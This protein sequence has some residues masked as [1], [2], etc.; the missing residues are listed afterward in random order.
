MDWPDFRTWALDQRIW[1]LSAADNL[2]QAQALIDDGDDLRIGEAKHILEKLFERNPNFDPAYIEV[3]RIA[4]KADWGPEGLHQVEDLLATALQIRPGN[5]DAKI[6]LAY[7]YAHQ[8]RFAKAEALSKA[9]AA[10]GTSNLW[11]WSN[12]GEMLEMEHRPDQA[13]AKYRRAI[14][15][16]VTRDRNDRARNFAYE[17]LLGIL[18]AREDFDAMEALYKQRI[19]EFGW[20]SCYSADYTGFLLRLGA[21]GRLLGLG[22]AAETLVGE[23]GIPAAFIPVID[24]DVAAVRLMRAHGVTY[25]KLR[26]RGVTALGIAKQQGNEAM[27][28][29]LGSGGTA[30]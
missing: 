22:A 20:G 1:T 13:I 2:K 18:K 3:A 23:P 29:A 11:L 19:A 15:H 30:L 27:L 5:T 12:W 6:L 7:V 16:P 8:R 10:T 25:A 24:G 28:S 14:G 9:V 26:Y 4:M 21:A 17:Q